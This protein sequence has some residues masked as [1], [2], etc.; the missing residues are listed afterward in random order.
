MWTMFVDE[1]IVAA[2]TDNTDIGVTLVWW[3]TCLGATTSCF[4][5]EFNDVC[6][7]EDFAGTLPTI[8]AWTFGEDGSEENSKKN[9]NM[10]RIIVQDNTRIFRS[11]NNP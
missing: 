1:T 7:A 2:G 11:N 4:A 3:L 10:N 9:N 6:T 5:W 8:V